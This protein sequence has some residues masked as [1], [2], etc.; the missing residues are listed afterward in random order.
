MKRLLKIILTILYAVASVFLINGLISNYSND[1]L[2]FIVIS[3][4]CF[5]F[6]IFGWIAPKSCFDLCWKIT[7]FLPD[8]YDYETSYSKLEVVTLGLLITANVILTIGFFMV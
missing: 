6:A 4:V 7:R 2:F 3:F 5:F 8:T 1:G